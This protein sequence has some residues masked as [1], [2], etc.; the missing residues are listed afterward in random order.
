[1][2]NK[3]KSS[4]LSAENIGWG[5]ALNTV[6]LH[7]VKLD[8]DP[9][10]FGSGC[11]LRVGSKLMLLGVRH[12]TQKP[13][14]WCLHIKANPGRGSTLYSFG[15]PWYFKCFSL[16]KPG[17]TDLDFFAVEIPS[18]YQ[19]LQQ[20][21]TGVNAISK[22]ERKRVFSIDEIAPPA[23]NEKYHFSGEVH[24]C[25]SGYFLESQPQFEIGMSFSKE[26]PERLIF[27]TNKTHKGHDAYYGCSGAPIINSEGKLVS[28]VIGGC[29]KNNLIFGVPL[30][31][32]KGAIVVSSIHDDQSN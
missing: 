15:A 17:S 16:A 2:P 31:T 21:V 20:L 29:H 19:P 18:T 4:K 24:H 7:A 26:E 23:S 30:N 25:L 22:E 5:L 28:L 10:G 11:L 32:F 8:G 13:K 9:D 12:V 27:T 1:M 3:P 14:R 6:H